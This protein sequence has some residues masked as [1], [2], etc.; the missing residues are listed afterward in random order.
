MDFKPADAAISRAYLYPRDI[1]DKFGHMSQSAQLTEQPDASSAAQSTP[2]APR[3][4]IPVRVCSFLCCEHGWRAKPLQ[5]CCCC[6]Y[7]IR[8]GT[9]SAAVFLLPLG[10]FLQCCSGPAR[11]AGESRVRAMHL[12]VSCRMVDS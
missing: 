11:G 2:A 5:K 7:P 1:R 4:G 10:L 8:K 12:K 6:V 3:P 9:L